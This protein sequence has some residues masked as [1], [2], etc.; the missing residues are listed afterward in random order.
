MGKSKETF[1]DL[2]NKD[3]CDYLEH[4]KTKARDKIYSKWYCSAIHNEILNPYWKI[5]EER[6]HQFQSSDQEENDV[7]NYILGLIEKDI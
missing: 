4:I 2:R 7:W 1:Q 3:D 5:D 6:A